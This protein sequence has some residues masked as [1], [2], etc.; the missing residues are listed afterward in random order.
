MVPTL[1]AEQNIDNQT[2]LDQHLL[3]TILISTP[4]LVVA[5]VARP[6]AVLSEVRSEAPG[7]VITE[8]TSLL[9]VA[10]PT[11][12]PVAVVTSVWARPSEQGDGSQGHY[13]IIPGLFL[14]S[15]PSR[16]ASLI[17]QKVHTKIFLCQ[18]QNILFQANFLFFPPQTWSH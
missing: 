16:I 1:R 5:D 15:N 18:G 7:A 6:D 3:T 10:S 14:L 17:F 2:P 12:V 11:I 9:P 13:Q 8:V 4:G